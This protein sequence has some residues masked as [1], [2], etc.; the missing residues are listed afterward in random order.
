MGASSSGED[1]GSEGR[2]RKRKKDKALKVK[3][4]HKSSKKSKK[5]KK[6]RA[7]KDERGPVQLSKVRF[8]AYCPGVALRACRMAEHAWG[9]LQHL[10]GDGEKYSVISGKKVRGLRQA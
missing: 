9:A 1:S 4:K 6:S 8:G 3:K 7:E 2:E 10:H 5:E